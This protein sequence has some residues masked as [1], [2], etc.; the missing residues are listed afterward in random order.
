L[1][2]TSIALGIRGFVFVGSPP[3]L[4]LLFFITA[5]GAF[6]LW[7]VVEFFCCQQYFVF[8]YLIIVCG[9][10]WLVI[11]VWLFGLFSIVFRFGI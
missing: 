4:V 10:A 5:C 8:Y 2:A 9:V 6:F 7:V 11:W 3:L 1:F